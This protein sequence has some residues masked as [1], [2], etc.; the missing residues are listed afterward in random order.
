VRDVL[1]FNAQAQDTVERHPELNL[2]GLIHKLGLGEWF[3][4]YYL[5][6]MSGAIWSCPPCEMMNFP[7]RTLVR[8]FANH[9][10]LS[11]TGQPQW[12]TVTG[13]ARE[14]V[15]RLTA[16]FVDRI[17]TNCAAVSVTRPQTG[18]I[19]I[20]DSTG[21]SQ[22]YDHVVMASHGNESSRT[23]MTQSGRY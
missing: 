2:Q 22:T 5:L 11:F 23:P 15:C 20:Q 21:D 6:P 1:K 13:G 8:F 14:Y 18:K 19:Q 3:R 12:H 4:R 9:H 16:P 17:R 7:A 10:L